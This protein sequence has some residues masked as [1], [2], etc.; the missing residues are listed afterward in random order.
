MMLETTIGTLWLPSPAITLK[1]EYKILAKEYITDLP[2][3]VIEDDKGHEGNFYAGRFIEYDTT[4]E[5][6]CTKQE[7]HVLVD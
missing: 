2:C 3:Y 6:E 1:K 4:I 7:D 5:L